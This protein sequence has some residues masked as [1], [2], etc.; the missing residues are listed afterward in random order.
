MALTIETPRLRLLPQT[1][2]NTKAAITDK[3]LFG[4]LLNSYVPKEWPHEMLADAEPYFADMLEKDPHSLGWWGWYFTLKSQ[5]SPKDI[6][7]GSAGFLGRP[8]PDGVVVIGYSIL[9]EFEGNGY[10]TEAVQAL[11][12][13][14]FTHEE[15]NCIAAETFPTL[16]LSIRVLEKCGLIYVGS[17]SDEGS[18]RYER[19][20]KN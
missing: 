12:Q 13:W 11:I 15:V 7:I 8:S 3:N 1:K 9:T 18:I 19:K 5:S 14:A 17:G 10:T 16:P 4:E 2:D 20:K 6:L